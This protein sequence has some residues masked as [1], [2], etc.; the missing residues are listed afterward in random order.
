MTRRTAGAALAAAAAAASFGMVTSAPPAGAQGSIYAEDVTGNFVGDGRDELLR[1]VSGSTPDVL[2]QFGKVGGPGS[3]IHYDLFPFTA[4]GTYDPIAGDFDGDGYDEILWYAPGPAQDVLW[5]FTSYSTVSSRAYTVNGT[6]TPVVGDFTGD[7]TDD[8]LW[9][10][11]GTGQDVL[12]EYNAGGGYTSRAR[13]INGTYTPIAGSFGSNYTD[14]ILWYAPGTGQDVLWDYNP[15][16]SYASRPYTANGYYEPF[17]L[18]IWA[19]GWQGE[20]IFWYA[21]GPAGDSVWDFL[22]GQRYTMPQQV[23]GYYDTAAGNFLGDGHSDVLWFA[24]S[25]LNVWD[26]DLDVN[27]DLG[28]WDYSFVGEA[29][30]E[31][32]ASGV[33]PAEGTGTATATATPGPTVGR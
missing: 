10:K 19:D 17:V 18:D 2:M 24:E 12:W 5:N 4:N 33:A 23:N 26:Y 27:G 7:Y 31:A 22:F 21:P 32:S 8:I 28:R 11:P 29:G 14:D 3:D 16:G 1:Y 13:T 6:Y 30:A 25:S 15:N 9:Y 20:D